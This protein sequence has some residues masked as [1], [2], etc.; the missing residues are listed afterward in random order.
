MLPAS[1]CLQ[2]IFKFLFPGRWKQIGEPWR[3]TQ[4]GDRSLLS[5][6]SGHG[7][8]Q[9]SSLLSLLLSPASHPRNVPER[10]Q[11]NEGLS[12]VVAA[13]A[14]LSN[15]Q[16]GTETVAESR[17]PECWAGGTGSALSFVC[18]C[19]LLVSCPSCSQHAAQV[20]KA[21]PWRTP[22]L[23]SHIRS[24]LQVLYPVQV[25]PFIH[26]GHL[27]CT[28]WHF[29]RSSFSFSHATANAIPGS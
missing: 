4:L 5:G 3:K 26:A 15:T 8:F 24:L 20:G 10:P 11:G 16:Q 17:E 27:D 7:H 22:E 25:G 12:V 18:T 19:W 9:T 23:F 1:S 28:P 13:Q 14:S 21:L 6:H 29:V 2:L